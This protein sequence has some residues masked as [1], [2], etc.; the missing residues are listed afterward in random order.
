MFLLLT[1]SKKDLLFLED[2]VIFL[3]FA[4]QKGI[5]AGE[6]WSAISGLYLVIN[7]FISRLFHFAETVP[8]ADSISV[9]FA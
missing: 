1:R 2:I 3:L 5:F 9:V 8:K 7:E 6:G 4:K